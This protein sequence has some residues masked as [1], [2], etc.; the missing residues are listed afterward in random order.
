M[1]KNKIKLSRINE[2]DSEGV[3][4]NFNSN[5]KLSPEQLADL[6]LN[7]ILL[8]KPK[9]FDLI[10]HKYDSYISEIEGERENRINATFIG[11]LRGILDSKYNEY[12]IEKDWRNYSHFP[13]FV[14]SWLGKFVVRNKILKMHIYNIIYV[15]NVSKH[16]HNNIIKLR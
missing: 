9:F 10:E 6:E 11:L 12:M 16:H 7:K 8:V 13:E 4:Q 1:S 3:D 14:Y 15:Y 2:Y 5:K